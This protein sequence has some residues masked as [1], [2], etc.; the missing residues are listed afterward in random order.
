MHLALLHGNGNLGIV[1]ILVAD[2]SM[3]WPRKLRVQCSRTIVRRVQ[4]IHQGCAPRNAYAF[5]ELADR[6]YGKLKES[7]QVGISPYKD[8]A[9]E[10]LALSR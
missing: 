2:R 7:H 3:I 9:D 10:D 5:K 6:A 1:R 8:L 4:G